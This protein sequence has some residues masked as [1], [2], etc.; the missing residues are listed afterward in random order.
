MDIE[1]LNEFR[2]ES[3]K[4]IAE[5]ETI[6]EQIED[7]TKITGNENLAEFAQRI[8]RIMGASKT[9]SLAEPDNLGL[10]EIGKITAICKE[11]GYKAGR[12][13]TNALLP[14]FCAFWADTLEVLSDLFDSLENEA[15][16][17]NMTQIFTPMIRNR[18]EW[19]ATK[20]SPQNSQELVDDDATD[21]KQLI[22]Q[23]DEK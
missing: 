8:D 13:K 14:L 20:I 18:L 3:K 6:I 9:M 15:E 5:L 10:K 16:I 11:L 12:S 1:V 7:D 19:L 4:I 17:R 23:L 2:E 22:H 21:L